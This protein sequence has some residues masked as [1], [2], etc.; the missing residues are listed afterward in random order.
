MHPA[1]VPAQPVDTDS[2]PGSGSAGTDDSL[3]R[4]EHE[5]IQFFVRLATTIGLPK[6]LG[7]IFGFLYCASEPIPFEDVVAR[8]QLSKGSAS[9]GLR[10][11]QKLKAVT[12]VYVPG[13][14]RTF[15][16]AETSVR[17]L[18]TGFLN[19]TVRP[20]LEASEDHLATIASHLD[21]HHDDPTLAQRVDS[22]RTWHAKA[23]RL[24]PWAA[25]L[26]AP[27]GQA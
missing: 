7:E 9:Q 8:L 4:V 22:L 3:S 15:Y 12:T 16:Q 23:R 6:S 24:L 10:A 26:T 11:L 21:S 25:R 19:D 17:K 13:D 14:R 27:K 5:V 2:G 1:S 20:H 18:T